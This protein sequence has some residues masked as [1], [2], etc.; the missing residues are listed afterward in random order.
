MALRT[1]C[2]ECEQGSERQ[3]NYQAIGVPISKVRPS[4][5]DDE[6][7]SGKFLSLVL[8]VHPL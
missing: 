8:F 4:D 7:I 1:K 5:S 6:E 2:L 3:E